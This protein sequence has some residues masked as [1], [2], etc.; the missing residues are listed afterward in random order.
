LYLD[1]EVLAANVPVSIV[2][3]LFCRHVRF[4]GSPDDALLHLRR[5]LNHVIKRLRALREAIN[6]LR[7]SII[8]HDKI[9]L[10]AASCAL[11]LMAAALIRYH[12][13]NL[14]ERNREYR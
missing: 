6:S 11:R 1:V 2:A 10:R 5:P 3:A 9:Y 13:G 12:C 7:R 8:G 4:A 14:A